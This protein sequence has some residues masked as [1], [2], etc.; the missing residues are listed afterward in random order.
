MTC[1]I[2]DSEDECCHLLVMFSKMVFTLERNLY[3]L[4]IHLIALP[5]AHRSLQIVVHEMSIEMCDKKFHTYRQS[6]FGC[7]QLE[8]FE[9]HMEHPM[10]PCSLVVGIRG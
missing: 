9:I 1:S 10:T 8:L 7:K 4:S 5:E 3:F 6:P 2:R